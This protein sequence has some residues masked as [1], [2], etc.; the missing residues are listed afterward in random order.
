MEKYPG[1]IHLQN[2]KKQ[3]GSSPKKGPVFSTQEDSWGRDKAPET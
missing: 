2:T 3:D 1:K